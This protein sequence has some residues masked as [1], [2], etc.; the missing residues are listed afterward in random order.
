LELIPDKFFELSGMTFGVFTGWGI[1]PATPLKPLVIPAT[2]PESL[3]IN[4][5]YSGIGKY[6]MDSG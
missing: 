3:G 2:E 5:E 1:C 6:R 4:A